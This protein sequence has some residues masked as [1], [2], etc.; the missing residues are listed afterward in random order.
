MVAK[1]LIF[2]WRKPKVPVYVYV[3]EFNR[4]EEV[5]FIRGVQIFRRWFIGVYT[6]GKIED[7]A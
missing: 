3:P 4:T 1:P 6:F 5:V 2:Y 7:K